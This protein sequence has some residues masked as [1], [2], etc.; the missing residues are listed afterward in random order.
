[1][2]EE[3]QGR[4]ET[5]THARYSPNFWSEV[6]GYRRCLF[7]NNEIVVPFA[8]AFHQP[9][10]APKRTAFSCHSVRNTCTGSVRRPSTKST[11][12]VLGPYFWCGHVWFESPRAFRITESPECSTS[13]NACF[14]GCASFV[15]AI[16]TS[17]YRSGGRESNRRE[18]W[19]APQMGTVAA[20]SDGVFQ[21]FLRHR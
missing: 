17:V 14:R 18:W 16:E 13:H 3:F 8:L 1:M 10:P 19:L 11:D 7:L 6:S 20:Q 4:N 15:E 12:D 2:W 21:R 9:I 5:T